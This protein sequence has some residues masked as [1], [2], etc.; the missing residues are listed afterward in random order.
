MG[1]LKYLRR[2]HW[3][4]VSLAFLIIWATVAVLRPVT[5]MQPVRTI[6][7]KVGTEY[8]D[9]EFTGQLEPFDK[10]YLV[11]S[12]DNSPACIDLEGNIKWVAEDF[13]PWGKVGLGPG[14]NTVC[15]YYYNLDKDK[16]IAK[17][18]D[19]DGRLIWEREFKAQIKKSPEVSVNSQAVLLLADDGKLEAVDR[20][21]Q[22]VWSLQLDAHSRIGKACLPD[23]SCI[24]LQS[25]VVSRISGSGELLW[26]TQHSLSN[27]VKVVVLEDWIAVLD[28]L[29]GGV[30]LDFDSKQT[31]TLTGITTIKHHSGYYRCAVQGNVLLCQSVQDGSLYAYSGKGAQ[32]RVGSGFFYLAGSTYDAR[33]GNI[34]LTDW[35]LPESS[36]LVGL[37]ILEKKLGRYPTKREKYSR[38]ICLDKNQRRRWS[39]RFDEHLTSAP[40]IAPD[41]LVYV[42]WGKTYLKAFKP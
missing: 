38:L 39:V 1:F 13:A 28:E 27:A 3:L 42:G 6:E 30:C 32:R 36:R 31:G 12:E 4:A 18:R 25:Q 5:G 35:Y 2:Y 16:G 21:G 24:A 22:S 23:G 19:L 7:V 26:S 11:A 34:Y 10:R 29:G 40:V 33:S 17:L 8:R 15:N 9:L 20:N 41:G 37:Q 14:G